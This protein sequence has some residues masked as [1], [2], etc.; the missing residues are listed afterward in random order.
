MKSGTISIERPSTVAVS[1]RL[2]SSLVLLVLGIVFVF[3]VGLSNTSMAHNAAHDA[4][5]TIGFPCH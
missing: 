2:K 3:G 4:R 5:H 1:E